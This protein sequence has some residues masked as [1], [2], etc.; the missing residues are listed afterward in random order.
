[1]KI[2]LDKTDEKNPLTINQIIT[3]LETY[4]VKAERKS[5]YTDFE[6]LRQ[7]GLEIEVMRSKTTGYYVAN[8]QFALPDVKL[9]VEAVQSAD[10]ITEEKSEELINKIILLINAEQVKILKS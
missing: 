8:R 4:G 7:F 9:L 6:V 2:L 1:M 3:E 10:F 5:I